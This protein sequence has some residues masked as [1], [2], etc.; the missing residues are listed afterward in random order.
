MPTRKLDKIFAPNS[1]AVIVASRRKMSV[2]QPVLKNLVNS[3]FRGSVYPI[4]PKYESI[5]GTPC[6][7]SA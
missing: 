6:L 5:D 3:E 7:A 4:N 2:G 1:V